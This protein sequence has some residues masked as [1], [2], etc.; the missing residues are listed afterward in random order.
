MT[1]SRALVC[2]SLVVALAF[3]RWMKTISGSGVT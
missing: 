2:F 3:G 1:D